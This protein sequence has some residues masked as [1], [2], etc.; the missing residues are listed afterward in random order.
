[1]KKCIKTSSCPCKL[2]KRIL[3]QK[4]TGD[5]MAKAVIWF[6][7][8]HPMMVEEKAKGLWARKELEIA[9]ILWAQF[10]KSWQKIFIIN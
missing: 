1:M 7:E 2:L 4:L 10:I 6:T 5:P 8:S 9:M 3:S